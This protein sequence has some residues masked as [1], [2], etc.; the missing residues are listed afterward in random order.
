MPLAGRAP[1]DVA[2]RVPARTAGAA[3]VTTAEDGRPPGT[4]ADTPFCALVPAG[5][6]PAGAAPVRTAEDGRPPGTGRGDRDPSAAGGPAAP[7]R[8]GAAKAVAQAAGS[9]SE[10]DV[11]GSLGGPRAEACPGKCT[12]AIAL[13]A[14]R[15]CSGQAPPG[16]VRTEMPPSGEADGEACSVTAV[17]AVSA[18]LAAD[19]VGICFFLVRASQV[20]TGEPIPPRTVSNVAE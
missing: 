18:S 12:A 2:G 9:W 15:A 4:T 8:V 11:T 6:A 3:P 1:T 16:W 7:G 17:R 14:P 20:F 10:V 5:R 13:R 19:A